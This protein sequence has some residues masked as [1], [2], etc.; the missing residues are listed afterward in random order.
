[1]KKRKFIK[2]FLALSIFAAF[3][4]TQIC[5][6]AT[7]YISPTGT[8]TWP[9]CTSSA[10]PCS[11][12]T[13]NS[14]AVAGDTVYLKGGTYT[15]TKANEAG[16]APTHSGTAAN[17]ITYAA[18]PGET[19]IITQS[20]Y[21]MTTYGIDLNADNYIVIDGITFKNIQ[22]WV[23][24]VNS[25][26]YNEIKNC[27]FMSEAGYEAGIG[28]LIT[29]AYCGTHNCWVTN[30]WIHHNTF[31]KRQLLNPCGESTDIMR[32]GSAPSD[33]SYPKNAD[34]YNTIE[35]NY[36][37]YAGHTILDNFG[38]Y[39]V[40]RNNVMHNEPWITGCTTSSFTPIY[41]NPAYNGKYGHRNL[42]L[43]DFHERDATYVL[44]E[45][46]RIGHASTNPGNSGPMNID[47]AAPKNI[48]RYNY[49]Y[50][51]M[52]A[53]IYFK[54][55]GQVSGEWG[56][57]GGINNRVYNNTIYHHGYGY[58]WIKY[59]GGSYSGH[60][61][62]QYSA[63]GT[64]TGNVIKNNIVYDNAN[65][66]ICSLWSSSPCSPAAI[67]T[68]TNNWVTANGEPKFV[69]PDLTNT[70]S[71]TLPDLSLQA[72]STAINGGTYL[73][74]AVGAGSNST[75]LVVAD[76]LY[77]QDGTWGSSLARNVT[78]FPDWIAIGTVGNVVRISSINYTTNTITL[79][80][81]MTWSNGASIWL[82]KKSDGTQVL[83]GSAPDYGACEYG[84]PTMCQRQYDFPSIDHGSSSSSSVGGGGG[85]SC[86]IA[87]AAFGSNLDPHVNVLRDFRDKYLLTNFVGKVFVN[88]Y[89]RHSPPI[90]NFI[91]KHETLKTAVGWALT[92]L[93]Y[94]FEYPYLMTLFL[95]IPVGIVLV[96]RRRNA[97][98]L[99]KR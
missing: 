58:D 32:I 60:G 52:Q 93:V 51:G 76:A 27:I 35:N 87:T 85:G 19:P 23:Y 79:A 49:L 46:N 10:T 64:P 66:D 63:H 29:G 92:P 41:T 94:C 61:I 45:G 6:A 95:I 26:S 88:F 97:T 78:H 80:S 16:I 34:N 37:E 11:L 44:V 18:A 90:A 82:Y 74:T 48:I 33:A 68:V 13:A 25:S 5:F 30:N 9:A 40:I 73:T 56:Y 24:I 2:F 71:L 31:S 47:A 15:L 77:F 67:D 17:K 54:Y 20:P 3:Y 50:N 53:G 42:Q 39:T 14:N 1:M 81:A 89:Y 28:V 69:N 70:S 38:M 99:I 75:T 72:G 96:V 98:Y 65:G 7:H 43:S 86:A 84:D 55:A 12:S 21:A 83:Y 4:F 36:F 62:A 59:G 22:T 91:A 57:T 8:A